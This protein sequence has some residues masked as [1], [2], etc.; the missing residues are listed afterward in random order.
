V[1]AAGWTDTARR[2]LTDG[3]LADARRPAFDGV[4]VPHT[5]VTVGAS[6]EW[7]GHMDRSPL[8]RV[9]GHD[10]AML[11]AV[12]AIPLRQIDMVVEDT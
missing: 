11:V 6:Y 2:A 9:T 3:L 8:I 4:P 12:G 10:D 7:G 1:R 5:C